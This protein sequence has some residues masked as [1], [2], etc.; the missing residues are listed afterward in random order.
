MPFTK[1]R[2][3]LFFSEEE[4]DRLRNVQRSRRGEQRK[5]MRAS[6]LLDSVA[7]LN[8]QAVAT[9]NGVNRNTVVRCIT[10]CLQFGLDAALNDL[11]RPGKP[12]QLTDDAI[13]WIVQLA[14]Q[15][16]KDLGYAQELW[17]YRL[18]TQQVRRQ[19]PGAGYP[20]LQRLSRSKLHH[21]LTETELRP[22]KVRYYVEK[23]DPDFEAKMA[24]VLHVYKEV[25][26]VN[27]GLLSGINLHTG[28]ITEMVSETHKSKDFV[29][30]LQKLDAAYPETAVIRL[31]LDNSSA[32]ISKET[33]RY[34][35]T[36]P[37]RF[38]F[39]FTPAHGSWLNLIEVLFS[40]LT[41]SLLR[42]IRVASK[43]EL[44]ERLHQYFRELNQ[45]PVVFRWKYDRLLV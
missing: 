14:C 37:Q 4:M 16:P 41:R 40:K 29:E 1:R 11:Q 45:E 6:V 18:L 10:K 28:Q 32:H 17:T 5:V 12:R 22:H 7:G 25:E 3:P 42:G 13:A 44:I 35:A 43:A 38:V 23:R 19:G 39:V 26:I 8:D 27:D 36:R 30:Y 33:R 34:L 9:K 21:L 20:A 2:K 31:V 24:D 15:K